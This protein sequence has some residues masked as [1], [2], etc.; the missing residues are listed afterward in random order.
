MNKFCLILTSIYDFSV[1]LVIRQLEEDGVNYFRLNKESVTDYRI[2][3]DPISKELCISGLGTEI[4]I[5]EITSIWYRL[6]VFLRNT[7]NKVLSLEEQ[8]SRS[9]WSAFFRGLMVFDESFWVNWPASTYSAESKPYQLMVASRIGFLTPNTHIGNDYQKLKIVDKKIIVKSLDT[10]LLRENNDCLFA[11]TSHIDPSGLTDQNVYYAP[12]TSQ[13]YLQPKIDIRVTVIGNTLYSVQILSNGKGISDDWRLLKKEE[14]EYIDI[15]LPLDI[16]NKCILLL[17]ELKLVYGAI[18]LIKCE[19]AYY[20]IEINPTGEWGWLSS[21]E[22][23]I[24]K[25]LA[26]LLSDGFA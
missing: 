3:I 22:R 26:K 7:P 18:D 16:Q 4:Q 9:Q 17:K 6:P 23:P 8:L 11:Y 10:L 2:N 20:F 13:S 15:D 12:L 24:E 19:N 5:K 25:D 1:D 21:H 14:L